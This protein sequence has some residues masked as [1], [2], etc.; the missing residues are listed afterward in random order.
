MQLRIRIVDMLY[1]QSKNY[2]NPP[3]PI[4]PTLEA[5]ILELNPRDA[6]IS[7]Y[8]AAR[9]KATMALLEPLFS[10]MLKRFRDLRERASTACRRF[11][12]S[13]KGVGD[14]IL[15][16]GK[17]AARQ[18]CLETVCAADVFCRAGSFARSE[19][20]D[21]ADIHDDDDSGGRSATE[22]ATGP[23]TTSTTTTVASLCHVDLV[24]DGFCDPENN[25]SDCWFDGGDCRA[26]SLE[27]Q[28]PPP[29]QGSKEL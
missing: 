22:S 20:E 10:V 24:G 19:D 25:H 29:P 14:D 7:K 8:A 28:Q 23:A 3:Q 27:Q 26:G 9:L 16:P 6:A 2:S 15:A 18:R 13:A 17:R 5:R 11:E 1:L 21:G 12:P 4:T